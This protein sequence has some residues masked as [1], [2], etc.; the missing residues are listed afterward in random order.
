VVRV[1]AI[2][3]VQH[4]TTGACADATLQTKPQCNI[5]IDHPSQLLNY[6]FFLLVNGSAAVSCT[7]SGAV[8]D[9]VA[10]G[11]TG[12]PR[13][14]ACEMAPVP[15]QAGDHVQLQKVALAGAGATGRTAWEATYSP[16]PLTA[17]DPWD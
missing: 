1:E 16:P 5:P 17:P 4:L 14:R 7:V 11:E 13:V 3:E 12:F 6:R 15:L 8:D 10:G 2:T 9:G